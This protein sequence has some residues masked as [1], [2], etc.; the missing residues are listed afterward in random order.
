MWDWI[1]VGVVKFKQGNNGLGHAP[2]SKA[3]HYSREES[4]LERYVYS[5]E[6]LRIAGNTRNW[7]EAGNNFSLQPCTM[8]HS[9]WS[10]DFVLLPRS[11]SYSWNFHYAVAN[12]CPQHNKFSDFNMYLS[13][14][15]KFR[16]IWSA[17]CDSAEVPLK[18]HL[19]KYSPLIDSA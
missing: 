5:L 12:N 8:N 11:R 15:S 17:W 3:V 18:Q 7:R 2:N 10:C 13:I 6:T 14:N 4:R 19:A 16:L 9:C 1:L